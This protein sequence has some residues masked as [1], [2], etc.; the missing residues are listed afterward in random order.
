MKIWAKILIFLLVITT[1]LV[2]TSGTTETSIIDKLSNSGIEANDSTP[3]VRMYNAVMLYSSMYDIPSN[4]A[5]ALA[6]KETRYMGPAQINYNQAIS[7]NH[8]ALGPMQIKMGTAKMFINDSEKLTKKLLK[9]DIELNVR[10]S[11]RILRHLKDTYGTWEKAFGAYNTG[12]PIVNT[13]ARNIT[14]NKYKWVPFYK[15][16]GEL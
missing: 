6:Y 7:S 16:D 10:L 2:I 12:K 8:G 13:Y 4:Y 3:S 9:D 14:S 1:V 15:K 5:F 11:M